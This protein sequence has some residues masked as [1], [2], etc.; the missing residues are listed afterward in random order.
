MREKGY[1]STRTGKHPDGAN[2][3]LATLRRLFY[4]IYRSF[5]HN[6]Y[7]QEAF[8]YDCV[9]AGDVPGM[10]G[11]D[12]AG[13]LFVAVRKENLWP[14]HEKITSYSEDDVFDMIEFLFD[15]VSKPI[16]GYFHDHA[17]CGMHYSTFNAHEGRLEF[18]A[19]LNPILA[20]YGSGFTLSEEGEV[21]EL[22]DP[23]LGPLTEADLPNHDPENI[24]QRVGAAITRFRRHRSSLEDRRHALRDLADVLEFLRPKVRSSRGQ[25]R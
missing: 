6:D 5:V 7:F 10:L 22:P 8:G 19:K 20:I 13:A 23:G 18:R 15:H 9:D 4:S 12:I 25:E 16:D 11:E 17:N 2:L 24:E 21:L 3:D 1:Y 14:I